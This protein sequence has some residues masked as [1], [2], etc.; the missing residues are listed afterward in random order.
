VLLQL[1]QENLGQ[2]EVNPSTGAHSASEAALLRVLE[3]I[4][5]VLTKH[6]P[7]L[8]TLKVIEE[9]LQGHAAIV[10]TQQGKQVTRE[11]DFT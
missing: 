4:K 10:T 7:S 1:L 8:A 2:F 11:R 6:P 5:S 3:F 9:C